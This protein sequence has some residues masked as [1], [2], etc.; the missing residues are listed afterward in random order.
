MCLCFMIIIFASL[1]VRT[2]HYTDDNGKTQLTKKDWIRVGYKSLKCLSEEQ[3]TSEACY[4]YA[5]QAALL[6]NLENVEMTSD[7]CSMEFNK[8]EISICSTFSMAG[9]DISLG[10]LGV[11]HNL[12]NPQQVMCTEKRNLLFTRPQNKD[13][14]SHDNDHPTMMFLLL[15]KDVN[16]DDQHREVAYSTDTAMV[17]PE[18]NNQDYI[19]MA[20]TQDG[21]AAEVVVTRTVPIMPKSMVYP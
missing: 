6:G 9:A 15:E 4:R 10:M 13:T 3:V 17:F 18:E 11:S 5:K 7:D 14:T 16:D 20:I 1:P 12:A 21:L 8:D 19:L 2:S